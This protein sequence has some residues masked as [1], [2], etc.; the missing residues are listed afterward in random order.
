[1][2]PVSVVFYVIMTLASP[3]R[4]FHDGKP[5][6]QAQPKSIYFQH[7]MNSWEEC[8]YEVNEFMV[9]PSHE[10]LIRGGQVQIGCV[11]EFGPSVEH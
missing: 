1:M 8:L 2:N 10:L 5:G 7:R 3:N 9:K 6:E 4:D 11:T